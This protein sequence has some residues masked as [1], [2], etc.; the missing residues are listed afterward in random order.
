MKANRVITHRK[1][2]RGTEGLVG[3][4]YDTVSEALG[5]RLGCVL[6]QLPPSYRY[7]QENLERVVSQMDTSFRNVIEFRHVSW[8]REEVQVSRKGQLVQVQLLRGGAKGV[9]REA[10]V[11]FAYFKTTTTP[12]LPST[13]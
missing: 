3:E 4:F 12:T 7:S 11:V 8:W 2:F 5:E 13:A 9:G 6:F 10:K 1:K